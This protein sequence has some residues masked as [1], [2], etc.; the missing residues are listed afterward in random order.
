[1]EF[2]QIQLNYLDW[3][4]QDAKGKYDLLTERNIPVWVMEPLRGGKLA[5]LSE[6]YT[7]RLAA[8]RDE[9]V[10]AW[11]F[12]FLQS[13]P[14]VCVTLSGMSNFDQLKENIE[15][16]ETEKPTT[17]AERA[18]LFDIAREMSA[19]V[20]CTACRY[21]TTYCPKGLD[22]PTLLNL[23]N[24]EAFSAGGFLVSMQLAA[25]PEDKRPSACIGCRKCEAVCPQLI[26][27]PDVLK[28]LVKE[29]FG[30]KDVFIGYTGAVI[31][32]HSGPGTLALFFLGKHR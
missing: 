31:G 15:I 7:A 11:G 23:Y 2:C 22:I 3:T 25:L 10:P 17:E 14:E 13:V 29:K 8:L 32:S 9:S 4:L 6:K 5:A 12:R 21:C 1:M 18:E 27:I 26:K 28:K 19:A 24:E 20:P 30:V 16:F